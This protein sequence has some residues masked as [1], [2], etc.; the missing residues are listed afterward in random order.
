MRA[1]PAALVALSVEALLELLGGDLPGFHQEIAETVSALLGSL[2][3]DGHE[4]RKYSV[5]S[6]LVNL[7]DRQQRG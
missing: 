6:G 2:R 1:Q 5:R 4:L 3:A 7:N